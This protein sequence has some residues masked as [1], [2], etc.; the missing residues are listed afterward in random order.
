MRE[1]GECSFQGCPEPAWAA[2]PDGLCLCHSPQNG[3]D[4]L[5]A[6]ALWRRARQRAGEPNPDYSGWH[7]APDPDAKGFGLATFRGKATFTAAAFEGKADFHGAI[8]GGEADFRDAAFHAEADFAGAKFRSHANFADARFAARASFERVRFGAAAVFSSRFD[9][10]V[11]FRWAIFGGDADFGGAA[12]AAEADFTFA[13]APLGADVALD[14]PSSFRGPFRR[15]AAGETAYRLAKQAAMA[16]GDYGAAGEYH[17]AEQCAAEARQRHA[18]GWRPW[19]PGFWRSLLDLVF[20]RGIFGYG[21]RPARA[22]II[23]LIIIVLWA[24]LAY[25]SAGISRN[26]IGEPDY[27]PTRLECLHFSI[28]TFTTLGY[29]DFQP[30][31]HFLPWADAEAILGLTLM[32]VFIVGLTRRYMR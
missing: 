5:T 11:I 9:A 4:E 24:F 26:P 13:K 15:R 32:S 31:P 25:G 14:R 6:R 12:F 7:F 27:Q 1:E 10:D 30:K 21:E 8:F 17:Y 18:Y 2:D 19:H 29:G 3:R 16:R 20:A 23:G 22:L 28:V